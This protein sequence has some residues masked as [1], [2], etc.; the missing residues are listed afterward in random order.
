MGSLFR[1]PPRT[2]IVN[3]EVVEN[4]RYRPQNPI[5]FPEPKASVYCQGCG[6][7][8]KYWHDYD[9]ISLCPECNTKY[10]GY[11]FCIKE[12]RKYDEMADLFKLILETDEG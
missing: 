5:V 10:L 4:P 1:R 3:G 2:F 11:R 7:Y 8:T 6:K 12:L 9:E